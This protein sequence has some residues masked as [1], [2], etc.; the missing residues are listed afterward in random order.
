MMRKARS[1]MRPQP[2]RVYLAVNPLRRVET[3]MEKGSRLDGV[4]SLVTDPS[5]AKSITWK[6]PQTQAPPFILLSLLYQLS[7][8]N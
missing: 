4:A 8:Q 6:N 3:E 1:Q 7:I 5:H 2:A